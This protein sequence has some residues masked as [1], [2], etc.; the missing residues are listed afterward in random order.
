MGGAVGNLKV[1]RF[2]SKHP[3]VFAIV[4]RPSGRIGLAGIAWVFF[5]IG[6]RLTPLPC[7]ATE[8][9]GLTAAAGGSGDLDESPAISRRKM[10][11]YKTTYASH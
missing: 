5:P 2:F 6:R 11:Y 4:D 8:G 10:W 7:T 1:G 3:A 9:L